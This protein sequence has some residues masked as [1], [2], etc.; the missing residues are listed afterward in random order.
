[1][2]PPT[3][4]SCAVLGR[5]QQLEEELA[6]VGVQPVRE[7]LQPLGLAL[8]HLRVAVRVVTDE[9]LGG[10]QVV[11]GDVV[12]EV[13]AVLELELVLTPDFSAGIVSERPCFGASSG[14]SEPNCSS[15]STPAED[16]SRPR[17]TAFSMPS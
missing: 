3:D 8:V 12:G 11:L 9:H 13:V 16:A 4:S 5:D 10:E 7:L 1:M 2:S 17:S 14:M 6:V 15:T